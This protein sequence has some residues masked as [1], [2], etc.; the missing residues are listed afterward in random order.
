AQPV[1]R[2]Q[3]LALRGHVPNGLDCEY[4]RSGPP[5]RGRHRHCGHQAGRVGHGAGQQEVPH[6]RH[7]RHV[8]RQR[9]RQKPLAV[10]VPTQV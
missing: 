10:C 1:R 4:R 3:G 9:H 6:F 7:Q 5:G 8:Q 2:N